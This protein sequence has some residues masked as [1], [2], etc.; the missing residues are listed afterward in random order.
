MHGVDKRKL[1]RWRNKQRPRL[2]SHVKTS[3][4][5]KL[6]DAGLPLGERQQE[7][8]IPYSRL[9]RDAIGS[10]LPVL[11]QAVLVRTA[12]AGIGNQPEVRHIKRLRLLKPFLKQLRVHGRLQEIIVAQKQDVRRGQLSKRT[13][14]A[15]APAAAATTRD[16]PIEA[17]PV[18]F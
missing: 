14:K 5:L 17:E 9:S 11:P 7:F 2:V 13:N 10:L 4:A 18:A 12:G 16:D 8:A 15:A 1:L 3:V 6:P